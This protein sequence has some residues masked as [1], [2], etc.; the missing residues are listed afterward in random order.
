MLFTVADSCTVQL[1]PVLALQMDVGQRARYNPVLSQVCGSF[2]HV[3]RSPL[4]SSLLLQVERER[5]EEMGG[6]VLNIQGTWRVL[7]QLAVS[8]A[9][10]QYSL[11][12]TVIL[13]ILKDS[14]AL[15][16]SQLAPLPPPPPSLL[17]CFTHLC[18]PLPQHAPV[19][20]YLP[21]IH[22]TYSLPSIRPTSDTYLLVLLFPSQPSTL[23]LASPPSLALVL[24]LPHLPDCS[25][26]LSRCNRSCHPLDQLTS[27]T[28][29][30]PYPLPLSP[31]SPPLIILR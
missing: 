4:L 12:S 20:Q 14:M 2:L 27:F 3:S 19:I 16:S 21:S 9:I 25:S 29:A 24:I 17:L 11:S 6:C 1:V 15:P 23:T 7:G 22:L 31:P 10:G 26:P 5:V 8:R 30:F 13:L 18:L 28:P